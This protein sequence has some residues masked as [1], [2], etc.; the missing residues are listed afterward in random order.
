MKIRNVMMFVAAM[1][2][3]GSVAGAQG[4]AEQKKAAPAK[5]AMSAAAASTAKPNT[6]APGGGAS[7]ATATAATKAVAA[8]DA[9][10]F[11]VPLGTFTKQENV[12]QVQGKVSATGY[13]SY[14]EKLADSKIRLRAGPFA[15]RDAAEQE[16]T[17]PFLGRQ[18][19]QTF[20]LPWM[21]PPVDI[22][23]SAFV[24]GRSQDDKRGGFTPVAAQQADVEPEDIRR[25]S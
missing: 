7:S 8:A 2:V 4:K 15:S 25:Q 13:K 11:F 21:Q 16:L 10:S 23:E 19:A 12:R 20:A 22:L 9:E 3:A 6:A 1:M 5:A 24:D 18:P 14:S 17:P